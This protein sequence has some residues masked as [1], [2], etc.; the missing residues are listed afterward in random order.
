ME[1]TWLGHACFRIRSRDATILTDPCARSTGYHMGKPTADIVTVSH[2]HPGHNWVDGVAGTPRVI[3]GPGEYEVSNVLITGIRTYHDRQKGAQRGRNVVYL[4][5]TEGVRL[6]HLGDLGHVPSDEQIEEMSDIGILFIPVGGGSTIDARTATE[7]VNLLE[8][9][10]V[11][12]MHYRTEASTAD[13]APVDR[14]LK[15]MGVSEIQPQ[16]KLSINRSQLPQQ[17]QVVLL[18]HRT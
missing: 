4:I 9:R 5:E 16:A 12:P 18:E 13:L 8:P 1:I 15:E 6:C 10:L 14:F 3:Y 11:I 7:V 2:Q 17:T